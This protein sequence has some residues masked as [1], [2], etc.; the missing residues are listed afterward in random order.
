MSPATGVRELPAL[1]VD[2][3]RL[4]FTVHA[5]ER[6]ALP[7]FAGSM[8]RGAYGH[9]LRRLVC[10]TRMPS[11]DGC[12]LRATCAFPRL[13]DPFGLD[14]AA[15]G[16]A[17]GSAQPPPPFAIDPPPL[18]AVMIEPGQSWTFG[19]RLFGKA[20]R[21]LPLIV[22]AWRRALLRGLGAKRARGLLVGVEYRN[23]DNW[24]AIYDPET[25]LL[26]EIP[27]I[28]PPITMIS[29][30]F[31]GL[32]ITFVTPLRLQSNARRLKR[33]AI[34]ARRL[35]ADA[36][37]R[38]RPIAV[39]AG[40]SDAHAVVAGWP[41]RT[42]LEEAENAGL[43]ETLRWIDWTRQSSRQGQFITL[44]GWLGTITVSSAS[45]GILA[46]LA[47]GEHTGLGKETVFGFGQ[48][49]LSARD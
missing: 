42:W 46:A 34:T 35:V 4:R 14:V 25:G 36:L 37:R 8:L 9:A 13:F 1:P 17:A 40:G 41:V 7:F 26:E 11:C 44:G 16:L 2:I 3:A 10:M 20:I 27:A 5:D 39:S 29:K 21:D 38:A 19:Q 47:I 24:S 15:V 22:E 32:T 30:S 45:G 18:G 33:E 43:A 6:M 31:T 48:Y 28:R 23:G 12:P 49:S